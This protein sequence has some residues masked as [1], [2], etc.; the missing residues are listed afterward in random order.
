M[1]D[2][3]L[4]CIAETPAGALTLLSVRPNGLAGFLQG[5]E[6]PQRRVL[7]QLGFKAA[8]G[9]VQLLAGAGGIAGAVLSLGGDSS[10][11]PFGSAAMSL[12]EGTTWQLAPGDYNAAAE[13]WASVWAPTAIPP[14]RSRPEARLGLFLHRTRSVAS[15][16]RLP[17]G[18]RAT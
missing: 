9:E 8:A 15:L 14:S 16:M 5:L 10:H 4:D 13:H 1:I 17:S 2:R 3:S 11:I 7:D 18:W 6:P 12:P